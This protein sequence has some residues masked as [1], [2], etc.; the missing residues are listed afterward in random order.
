M[1]YQWVADGTSGKDRRLLIFNP[2]K[3]ILQVSRTSP[4]MR[5]LAL[6]FLA[7]LT[8][9]SCSPT[10]PPAGK[11]EGTY[12][13]SDT[14]IV[15]RL[16]IG[17]DGLVKVSAPDLLNIGATPADER[18]GMRTQLAGDL[19]AAWSDVV[20]RKMDFD[21]ETFRKP[22]GIAPQMIWKSKQMT[23]VVYLGTQPSIRIPLHQ[24]GD[25]SDNPWAN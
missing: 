7:A 9:F 6:V 8:L 10:T 15:A 21:G 1:T 19:A 20:P 11:W 5:N 23:L 24:V 18:G 3:A 17:A 14:M 2:A 4:F 12:E 25:F 16:E 13:S 22:G